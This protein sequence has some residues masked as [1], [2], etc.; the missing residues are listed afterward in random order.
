MQTAVI[1]EFQLV[2][3]GKNDHA[4]RTGVGVEVVIALTKACIL[5]PNLGRA[6]Q[7]IETWDRSG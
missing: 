4:R 1:K 7:N 6:L 2:S 3:Q 5:Y